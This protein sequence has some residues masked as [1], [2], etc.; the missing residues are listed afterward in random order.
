MVYKQIIYYIVLGVKF[1]IKVLLPFLFKIIWF[2]QGK[3]VYAFFFYHYELKK[4][5][6]QKTL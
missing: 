2:T 6:Q 1:L 4:K 3:I 5:L